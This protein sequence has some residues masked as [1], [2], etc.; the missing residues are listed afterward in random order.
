MPNKTITGNGMIATLRG[1][2]KEHTCCVCHIPI[3]PDEHYW[4]IVYGGSGL[5]GTCHPE[6]VC[7]MCRAQKMGEVNAEV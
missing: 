5:G 2:R 3:Y 1:A 6:R 4:E 7:V